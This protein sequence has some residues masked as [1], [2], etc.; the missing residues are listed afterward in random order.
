MQ[1][2]T[3]YLLLLGNVSSR[4][5]KGQKELTF[6]LRGEQGL[7]IAESWSDQVDITLGWLASYWSL[8]LL[9]MRQLGFILLS[10]YFVLSCEAKNEETLE[11]MGT[12]VE[13]VLKERSMAE[14]IMFETIFRQIVERSLLLKVLSGEKSRGEL[15]DTWRI[16]STNNVRTDSL[17]WKDL[18]SK[19][20]KEDKSTWRITNTIM[21][22]DSDLMVKDE[23]LEQGEGVK[24]LLKMG[25]EQS[26]AKLPWLGGKGVRIM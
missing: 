23:K 11:E 17:S 25:G 5:G 7:H 26:F 14:K 21:R 4:K 16:S 10:F 18:A 22:T 9:I 15:E 6:S 24:Q 19:K 12:M 1:N 3:F 2:K 8:D 13:K 20:E